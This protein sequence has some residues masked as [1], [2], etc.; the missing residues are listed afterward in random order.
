MRVFW[1]AGEPS[2]DIQAAAL[3]RALKDAV[4]EVDQA[5]WG[6]THMSEAGMK[7]LFDLPGKPLMG[8]VEVVLKAATIYRQ[9]QAVKQDITAFQPQV[10]IL[11]DYAG[12]NLRIAKWAKSQGIQVVYYIPP[13]I[14]AWKESRLKPLTQYSDA[15]LS[16]LPFEEHWYAARGHDVCY[17]GNP[18]LLKYANENMYKEGSK[19]VLLL[20]GSRMQEIKRLMPEFIALAQALPEHRFHVVRAPSVLESWPYRQ[21]P[22]NRWRL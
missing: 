4:P 22:G 11:V 17:V 12:F 19:K 6:G 5:G 21:L 15:I 13:K 16:I 14:W 20:P 18:L 10:L 1:I 7:Q 2:G 8:F 3:V 9:V